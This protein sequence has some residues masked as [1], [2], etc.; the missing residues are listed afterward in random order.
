MMNKINH[1]KKVKLKIRPFHLA[2]PA[3]NITKLS[4]W[5]IENFKCTVGRTSKEW[6]DLNFYG[7]Q[8]VLHYDN[9]IKKNKSTNI[10]DSENI[11][12]HHFGIILKYS[13]WDE[14]K[15]KLLTKVWI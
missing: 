14:L 5:Y 8:L 13:E 3:S 12:T 7:H 11:P 4:H 9:K 2:I 10:V 15:Q 1:S 6:I